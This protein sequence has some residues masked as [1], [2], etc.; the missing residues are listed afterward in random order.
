MNL[1]IEGDSLRVR[2][3]Q[4]ELT[5]FQRD[6]RLA[7]KLRFGPGMALTYCLVRDQSATDP[8]ADLNGGAIHIRL[9]TDACNSWCTSDEEAIQGQQAIGGD[10][11]LDIVVEKDF[12]WFKRKKQVGG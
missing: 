6:G 5:T 7:D 2:A 8:R 1:R 10:A 9:P 12:S 11:R 4:E 3:S